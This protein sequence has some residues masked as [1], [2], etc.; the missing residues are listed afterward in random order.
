MAVSCFDSVFDRAGAR[1]CKNFKLKEPRLPVPVRPGGPVRL[2]VRTPRSRGDDRSFSQA[3][4]SFRHVSTA[5]RDG[6]YY[7]PEDLHDGDSP[8]TVAARPSLGATDVFLC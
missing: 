2:G 5:Q 7:E 4:P 6:A 8:V 1:A 3:L